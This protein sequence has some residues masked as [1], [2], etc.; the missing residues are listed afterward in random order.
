MGKTFFI[1][2]HHFHHRNI[3]R[4]CDRP[5]VNVTEMDEHM[6]TMWNSVVG[7]DDRV[8]HG[9]DFMLCGIDKTTA[10]LQRLNGYKVLVRGNH[11]G[12]QN[13]MLRAG[14]DEVYNTWME[15]GVRVDH[16]PIGTTGYFKTY[17]MYYLY[18]HVH[19]HDRP[20]EPNQINICV[21]AQDYTPKTL[22]ELCG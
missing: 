12:T 19:N 10:M 9:G 18:G 4:Y 17:S 20:R 22:G 13:R 6:I 1:S 2:D 11:D 7:P 21:E 14:F 3:I 16:I 8:I 15:G 5:F